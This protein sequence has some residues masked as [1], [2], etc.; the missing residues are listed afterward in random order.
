MHLKSMPFQTQ[1]NPFSE[2][3]AADRELFV[4]Y[5]RRDEGRYLDDRFRQDA[6]ASYGHRDRPSESLA[7]GQSRRRIP[8]RSAQHAPALKQTGDSTT[9]DIVEPDAAELV[10][11]KTEKQPKTTKKSS[12]VLS[13]LKLWVQLCSHRVSFL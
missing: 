13:F 12:S 9:S 5:S 10:A 2:H 6:P 3:F 4:I 8:D 11:T 1:F 7:G